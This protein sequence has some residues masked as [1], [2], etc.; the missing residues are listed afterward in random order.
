V[1]SRWSTRRGANSDC[2][3]WESCASSYCWYSQRLRT[4]PAQRYSLFH[5]DCH[6]WRAALIVGTSVVTDMS[7][8]CAVLLDL[9]RRRSLRRHHLHRGGSGGDD[10]EGSGL[11]RVRGS[12][13]GPRTIRHSAQE[14]C[15]RSGTRHPR[16]IER[17]S[18]DSKMV[19]TVDIRSTPRLLGRV[20]TSRF[21]WEGAE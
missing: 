10:G 9:Y 2:P 5:R 12:D 11:R 6:T 4:H 3:M 14:L 16:H 17:S 1:P 18:E 13:H 20:W 19:T 7:Q 8:H 21:V 15:Y